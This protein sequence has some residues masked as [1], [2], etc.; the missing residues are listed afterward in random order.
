MRNLSKGNC[1]VCGDVI[2]K[3][4]MNR[5]LLEKHAE[6]DGSGAE[7]CCLIRAE[8]LRRRITGYILT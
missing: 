4:A 5:R 2:G 1:Y 8:G 3:R 6:Y 7:K